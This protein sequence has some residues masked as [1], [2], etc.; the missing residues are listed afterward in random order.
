MSRRITRRQFVA[1]S[2]IAG[3]TLHLP[4]PRAFGANNRV[5]V[6]V[7]GCGGKGGGHIKAFAKIEGVHVAAVS[8]PD[9]KRMAG[10]AAKLDYATAQH[11]DFRRI[12]DDEDIDAVVIATPNHWHAPMTIMACRAG[13]HVYV[14]KPVSHGIWEGRKMVEAARQHNRI[15][16]AGTQH[17]SDPALDELS[18]DI[19]AGQ[20][21]KVLWIHTARLG[22]RKPIGNVSEPTILPAHIDY[23]LWA[24]PAPL[25]PV[26]R[27]SFHYDWH[28]QWNWG[29]GETGN[30]GIHYIDDVLNILRLETVPAGVIAAGNRFAWN[31]D[32]QTPNVHLAL[33]DYQGMPLVVD[34]RNL[35]DP[36]RP[37]GKRAGGKSGAV[38]QQMRHG[39][40]IMCEGA[41][42]R[43]ARN[44]G[45][46]YEKDTNKQI[47]QY[48]GTG[49][50]GHDVNFIEA[51]RSGNRADLKAEIE[52]AHRSTILCHQAN[53][54]YRLGQQASAEQIEHA[55][56]QHP[57]ATA[58]LAD[59]LEQVHGN[60]VDLS[61]T[62]FVLGPRLTFDPE[63]ERFTGSH[64]DAANAYLRR[65]YREPFARDLPT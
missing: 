9:L 34:V 20:Y 61:K 56:H 18:A 51:I 32:G 52:V 13:K 1:G 19:A 15:V 40:Y 44:G 4:T 59:I 17:R 31:D 23:N 29:D 45:K 48:K 58:T 38:Y 7:V 33:F 57:D 49:G 30:W 11:Q 35:A 27:K 42:I 12:L 8:D 5:N 24:G 65:E 14:E 2:V 50:S 6:A 25:T 21:G 28:W 63:K 54:S 55:V 41:V 16:Q 37:E 62:P 64:A 43:M 26:M 10:G 36:Q 60:G 39:N 3:A 47:K 53:I 46:S 22:A